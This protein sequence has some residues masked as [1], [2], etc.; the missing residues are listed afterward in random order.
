MRIDSTASGITEQFAAEL[1][2]RLKGGETIVLSSDLGGGKT[3]FVRGL[4]RGMGS[5]DH[6]SSPTFTISREYKAEKLTLYHF[7]FYRLSDPG[8]VAAELKEYLLDPQA[9]VVIEWGSIVEEVLPPERLTIKFERTGETSRTLIVS[10][11][12][13]LIYLLQDSNS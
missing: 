4:A 5:A 1:G 7:D 9:V 8:V 12:V 10:A 3:T 13:A 2:H 11:P 6:V